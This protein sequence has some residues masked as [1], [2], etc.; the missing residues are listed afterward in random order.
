MTTEGNKLKE[1]TRERDNLLEAVAYFQ[2][3]VSALAI[4]SIERSKQLAKIEA[5]VIYL[6]NRT[7]E[8]K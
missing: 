2:K 6:R 5:E 4:E 8:I 1:I 3:E 7:M